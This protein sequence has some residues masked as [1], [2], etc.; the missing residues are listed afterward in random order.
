MSNSWVRPDDVL[1]DDVLGARYS[2]DVPYLQAW[3]LVSQIV[4][5]HEIHSELETLPTEEPEEVTFHRKPWAE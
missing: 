3:F 4:D 5:D 2:A 1:L